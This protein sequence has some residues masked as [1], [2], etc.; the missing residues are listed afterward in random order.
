MYIHGHNSGLNMWG[1]NL[2]LLFFLWRWVVGGPILVLQIILFTVNNI[3]LFNWH[4]KFH[5]LCII[6]Q[7]IQELHFI[8]Q[9]INVIH[10]IV[11]YPSF[12]WPATEKL[13]SHVVCLCLGLGLL[14][15]W[16]LFNSM[17]FLV[18]S[19]ILWSD[20]TVYILPFQ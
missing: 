19:P 7:I 18:I 8:M 17:R 11:H 2:W 5:G 12:A 10:A 20:V 16:C 14:V 9:Y 13:V 6:V 1:E 4:W 15:G 3:K